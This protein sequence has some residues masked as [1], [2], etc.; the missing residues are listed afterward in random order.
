M[1]G[2]LAFFTTVA[3]IIGAVAA[4]SWIA[5]GKGGITGTIGTVFSGTNSFVSALMGK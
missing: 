4:L 3:L 2:L 1:S 5:K